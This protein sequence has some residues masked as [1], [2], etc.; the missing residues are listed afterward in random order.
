MLA[1]F[2][3]FDKLLA[4][5]RQVVIA[6]Q[7]GLTTHLDAFNVANN[8]PDLLYALISGGAL[9]IAF[10]PVL[11]EILAKK[12]RKDTWELFSRIANLTFISTAILSI[13][14]AIF[15]DSL[16]RWRLGIAP[17]FEPAQQLLVTELMRLNL[18]GTLIFSI[19]GLVMGG[20]QANQHFLL[21]ALAP[22]LYNL[23]QIL[24]ALI[25][26]P[27][28][29]Y[30]IAGITL[31]AYGLG[32]HGLVYGV[33]VGALLHL[34]IQIPGLFMHGF[35]WIPSLGL[36]NPL[37][38]RVLKLFGPRVLTVF[39]VQ[40]IFLVRDNLASRLQEGSVTVLTYGW[41]IQQVPETLL[42]TALGIAILPTLSELIAR[43]QLP[44]FR[45]SIERAIRVLLA[46]TIP[47][48]GILMLGLKPLLATVFNFGQEGTDLLLW[49][50]RGYLLG[51]VGHSMLEIVNRS[52]YAR[53]NVRI[54]LFGALL[55][56]VIY[57]GLGSLLFRPL[58]AAGISL[59][60]SI[61]F[62]TQVIMLLIVLNQW[63]PERI[64]IGS[65][66]FRAVLAAIVG[67]VITYAMVLILT[68]VISPIFAG[69]G[70]LL[71]GTIFALP[72]IW[73]ELRILVRL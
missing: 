59:T 17:G 52:F 66:L 68:G 16:V 10:I 44:E 40:L 64:R 35:R 4:F 73:R 41:M 27:E 29:G 2:I 6:R 36:H 63:L 60:D 45:A 47:V 22:P 33:I 28:K 49:V 15:A 50:T 46:L 26:S 7:F 39:C 1:A 21:P 13:L 57:I 3:A 20:L 69:L 61:A 30:T 8:I 5:I 14:T 31:P 37:V 72:F 32:V 65:S 23:G 62:T 12:G 11:T 67:G 38:Q 34:A 55:N 53:Q 71:M 19:S 24:G 48:A 58:G 42:G 43:E 51:L 9:S 18:I 54:P 25:L 70:A 56:L